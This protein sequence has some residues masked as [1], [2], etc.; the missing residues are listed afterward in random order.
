[1]KRKRFTTSR[2][3]FTSGR[4]VKIARKDAALSRINEHAAGIDIGAP[5]PFRSSASSILRHTRSRVR[6]IHPRPVCDRR[7]AQGVRG[8]VSGYGINR[9][10]LG[11]SL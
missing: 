5:E 9:R 10:L 7:L 3:K 4:A 6:R 8:E 2:K 1:M 11:A